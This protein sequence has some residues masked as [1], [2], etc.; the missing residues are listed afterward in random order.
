M[1]WLRAWPLGGFSWGALGVAQ[2]DDRVFAGLATITGVWGVTFVVVA[3]N[4][5]LVEAVV[6]GGGGGRRSGRCAGGGAIACTAPD[7]FSVPDGTA[8]RRDGLGGR[9]RRRGIPRR[10]GRGRRA[11]AHRAPSRRWCRSAGP[12]LWGRARWIP[13]RPTTPRR[14]STSR[15]RSPRWARRRSWARSSITPTGRNTRASLAPRSARGTR[16]T[17]T[18]RP[19][20]CRSASTCRGARAPLDLGAQ[21]IPVDRTPGGGSHRVRRGLHAFGTPICFENSF[22][23]LERPSPGT[24]PAFLVVP[25][26]NASYGS[27]PRPRSTCS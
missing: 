24:V 27:R 1:D 21:Q 10:R 16:S 7:P 25:V 23:S 19:T 14:S 8:R 15:P 11:V 3:V 13:A 18:T 2:V 22:P 12:R 6:G 5:L 9:R 26:N 20:S 4:A 17:A